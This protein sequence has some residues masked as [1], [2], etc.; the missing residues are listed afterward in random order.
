MELIRT[1]LAQKLVRALMDWIRTPLARKLV[2]A[3]LIVVALA[4]IALWYAG[5]TSAGTAPALVAVEK[6][7][8]TVKITE[9]GDKTAERT[10]TANADG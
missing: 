6:G 2:V 7:D 4:G 1:P 9:R 3:L 10:I 8:L 5:T